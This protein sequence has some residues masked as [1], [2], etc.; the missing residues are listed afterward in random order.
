MVVLLMVWIAG[1][2]ATWD[3][4]RMDQ[5]CHLPNF[6]AEGF[7]KGTI[8]KNSVLSRLGT[9]RRRGFRGLRVPS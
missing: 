1:P 9:H 4:F 3:V 2:L 8:Q 7:L 6:P 5:S